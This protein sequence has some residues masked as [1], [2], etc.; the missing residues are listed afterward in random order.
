LVGLGGHTGWGGLL[1][2]SSLQIKPQFTEFFINLG[3]PSPRVML[4]IELT[5]AENALVLAKKKESGVEEAQAAVDQALQNLE[6]VSVTEAE[7]A[8]ERAEAQGQKLAIARAQR[9]L[10]IEQQKFE[11]AH[12]KSILRKIG[13]NALWLCSERETRVAEDGV[14]DPD[15]E[16]MVYNQIDKESHEQTTKHIKHGGVQSLKQTVLRW[17]RIIPPDDVNLFFF[18]TLMML[19][20]FSAFLILVYLMS[21]MEDGYT[22]ARDNLEELYVQVGK[23]DLAL[24]MGNDLCPNL[25]SL[26]YGNLTI[27][28]VAHGYSMMVKDFDDDIASFKDALYYSWHIGMAF[29]GYLVLN[30][31]RLSFAWYRKIALE[32]RQRGSTFSHFERYGVTPREFDTEV[33]PLLTPSKAAELLGQFAYGIVIGTMVGWFFITLIVQLF[34]W[35]TSRE[36]FFDNFPWQTILY[37]MGA[38]IFQKIVVDNVLDIFCSKREKRFASD[39]RMPNRIT[40]PVLFCIVFPIAMMFHCFVGVM[41][42][43]KRLFVYMGVLVKVLMRTDRT[44]LREGG[45]DKDGLF[46][47]FMATIEVL[48]NNGSYEN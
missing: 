19:I 8:L 33:L 48:H 44:L 46:F 37:A 16:S 12:A 7:K 30:A 1:I 34:A 40:K 22:S 41:D 31:I 9:N 14:V 23:A 4:E 43:M 11:K 38:V 39:T 15:G 26:K 21:F 36:T 47:S 29:M 24:K 5:K 28:Q 2:L 13:E 25:F 35:K 18:P 27:G 20:L 45:F 42:G 6:R 17:F 32:C 10:E 3:S